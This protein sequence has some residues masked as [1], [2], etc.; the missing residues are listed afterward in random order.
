MSVDGAPEELVSALQTSFRQRVLDLASG[1]TNVSD[2]LSST[3][4]EVIFAN[5]PLSSVSVDSDG[6]GV[7]DEIDSDDDNDGTLDRDDAFHLTLPKL[8]IPTVTAS[9]TTLTQMTM[10]MAF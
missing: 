3:R 4:P 1:D 8:S 7:G 5:V 6:D 9:A 10:T 2:F